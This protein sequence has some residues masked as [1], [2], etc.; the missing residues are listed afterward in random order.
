LVERV[1]NGGLCHEAADT[2]ARKRHVIGTEVL[3][4]P[5][6]AV[7]PIA[8]PFPGSDGIAAAA[9]EDEAVREASG[10]IVAPR[11]RKSCPSAS[12]ST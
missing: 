9:E 2:A 12:Y 7:N 6:Q 3:R 4:R 1:G 8:Q 11:V 5:A 10:P